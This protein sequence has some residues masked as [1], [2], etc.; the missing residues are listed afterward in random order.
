MQWFPFRLTTSAECWI[1]DKLST[2]LPSGAPEDIEHVLVLTTCYGFQTFKRGELIARYSGE[3][4]FEAHWL[5]E[6]AT[7][8]RRE[9]AVG[10]IGSYKFWVPKEAINLLRG[11]VLDLRTIAFGYPNPEAQTMQV[12]MVADDGGEEENATF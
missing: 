2:S 8:D 5:P 7:P 4:F 11:K 1:T 9:Y 3:P 10:E 12:L 6:E